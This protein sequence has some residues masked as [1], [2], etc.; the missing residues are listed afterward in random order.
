MK[1]LDDLPVQAGLC[2]YMLEKYAILEI[3]GKL[4]SLSTV[5]PYLWL[6]L[7]SNGAKVSKALGG[8][9]VQLQAQSFLISSCHWFSYT[10]TVTFQCLARFP[11]EFISLCSCYEAINFDGL[12][13]IR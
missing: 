4:T 8:H 2:I 12:L 7:H 6:T 5:Y 13:H 3:N 1:P 9:I 10:F 11:N